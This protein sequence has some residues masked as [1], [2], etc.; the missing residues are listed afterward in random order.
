MTP[1]LWLTLVIGLTLGYL[2]MRVY[3][4]WRLNRLMAQRQREREAADRHEEWFRVRMR[5]T[6]VH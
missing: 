3:V 4:R 6:N 2:G 1:E 5:R